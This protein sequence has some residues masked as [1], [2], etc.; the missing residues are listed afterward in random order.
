MGSSQFSL[1]RGACS[2]LGSWGWEGSHPSDKNKYV[3]RVGHPAEFSD[4]RDGAWLDSQIQKRRGPDSGMKTRASQIDKERR[5]RLLVVAHDQFSGDGRDVAKESAF[6]LV[7][8][9]A[10]ID[11]ADG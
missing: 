11:F 9:G 8:S 2:D 3:A 10:E 1:R 7:G 5:I 6:A 4:C